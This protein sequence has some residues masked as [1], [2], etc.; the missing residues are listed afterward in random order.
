MKILVSTTGAFQLVHSEQ[1]ELVRAHGDTVIEKSQWAQE[2]VSIGQLLVSAQLN[3]EAS[4]AEWLKT[5]EESDGDRNLAWPASS[6][7]SRS[8]R[9]APAGPSPH[10]SR[11]PPPRSSTTAG[12]PRTR[13]RVELWTSYLQPP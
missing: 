9:R 1:H 3:D 13:S 11:R 10:R 2:K 6:T 8:T 7:A 12:A 5:L 4:D